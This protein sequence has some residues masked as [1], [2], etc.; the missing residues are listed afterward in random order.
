[1]L[2]RSPAAPEVRQVGADDARRDAA[3]RVAADAR[4]LRED[5]RALRRRGVGRGR[6]LLE[7]DPRLPG[8]GVV[9]D[10]AQAH[11][12]VRDAAELGALAEVLAGRLRREREPVE[13]PGDHVA[14]AAELRHPEAMDHVGP[15]EPERR[16]PAER[17][18]QLVGGHDVERGIAELPPPLVAADGD[19][20]RA[21]GLDRGLG[22]EDGLDRRDR[23]DEQHER[24][25]DRPADLE[26]AVPAD[27]ARQLARTAL[28]V[29]DERVDQE[30]DH[31]HEDAERD[32]GDEPVDLVRGAPEVGLR[33][34]RA[35]GCAPHGDDD[36]QQPPPP[37]AE[38]R[39]GGRRLDF[40]GGRPIK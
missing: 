34:H 39:R 13:S 35:H 3:D 33:Q 28:A 19:L 9:D 26:Q 37:Q 16:R 32:P 14:L 12:G 11:V 6:R 20:Q 27:L 7:P 21:L 30:P 17:Q 23:D 5:R 29:A 40:R 36:R 8:L 22:P 38:A 1:M 10:H 2:G 25:R 15:L 18:V 24:G 31:D 4:A